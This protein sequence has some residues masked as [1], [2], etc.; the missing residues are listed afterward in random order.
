MIVIGRTTELWPAGMV[1]VEGMLKREG[2]LLARETT[3]SL[4][5]AGERTLEDTFIRLTSPASH[6]VQKA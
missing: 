1:I 2:S 4:A 3:R 5:G 6:Q